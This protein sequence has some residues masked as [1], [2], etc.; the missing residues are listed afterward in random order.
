MKRFAELLKLWAQKIR[1]Y[2]SPVFLALL[3]VSFTLWY[4][5]KLNYTYTTDFVVEVDVDGDEFRVPC[6]VKGKG[7]A[8]FGYGVY[9]SKSADIAFEEL[10]YDTIPIMDKTDSVVVKQQAR[11]LPSSMQEALAKRFSDLEIVSIGTIPDIDFPEN[12]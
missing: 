4:I 3:A 5:S 9:T 2:I 12:D 10:S 11:I 8:L 1:K 6:I 7:T